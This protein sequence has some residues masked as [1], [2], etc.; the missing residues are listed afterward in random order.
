MA[1]V[2]VRNISKFYSGE[3]DQK[4]AALQDVSLEIGDREFAVL[5]GP[6]GSGKTTLLRLLAG[7]EEPAQGEIYFGDKPVHDLP[8][9]DRDVA[10]VFQNHALYP[11]LSVHD[12]LAF[13]LKMRNFKKPEI[14]RRVQ[15][16]AHILG[17]KNLLERKA[18]SLSSGQRQRVAIG[19][20]IV[21]QPKV[22]LFDEPLSNLDAS[23][24]AQ[25]RAEL[26]A[27]Q[28]R[29]QTTMIYV[30]HDQ[31]EALTMGER[32]IVLNQGRVEQMDTPLALYRDPANQFVAGFFGGPSMN[33]IAG[34]LK[35]TGGQIRFRESEGGTIEIVFTAADRPEA[36]P[37]AGQNVILG[38]RPENFT[39]SKASQRDGREKDRGFRAL[40][41]FIEPMGA[42][43]NL[44]LQTGAHALICRSPGYFDR[45]DAGHRFQFEI[46]L[47]KVQLFDPSSGQRIVRTT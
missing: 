43:T 6:S 17:I 27:L 39:V 11:H 4:I 37:Y 35:E 2:S 23:V 41:D 26:I 46:D 30:T 3:K 12:N 25:M 16:A 1:T 38:I 29:L 13:G 19:R 33:F 20:A 14:K 15:N 22:F 42:E 24:Q 34:S 47:E 8:P 18:P 32:I 36:L 9:Q 10:M 45:T 28:Q 7:L 40:V 44:H 21:R 5:A 31:V